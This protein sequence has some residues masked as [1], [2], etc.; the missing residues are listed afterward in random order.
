MSINTSFTLG[1]TQNE[2]GFKYIIGLRFKYTPINL[3]FMLGW[4]QHEA[5]FK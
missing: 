5:G 4:T 2:A 3:R 1:L